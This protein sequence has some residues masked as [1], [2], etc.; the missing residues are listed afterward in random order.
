MTSLLTCYRLLEP[1]GYLQW[2][3]IDLSNRK[4]VKTNPNNSSESLEQL[5]DDIQK[6]VRTPF[7][8]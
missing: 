5:Q 6:L 7:S 1:G 2:G 3:E 8:S 4:T